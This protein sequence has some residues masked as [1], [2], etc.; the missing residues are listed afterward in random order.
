MDEVAGSHAQ[1]AC[2]ASGADTDEDRSS[3]DDGDLPSASWARSG[4]MRHPGIRMRTHTREREQ[5]GGSEAPPCRARRRAERQTWHELD[6]HRE[7]SKV[8]GYL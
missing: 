2:G 8:Q 3:A 7:R 4:A 1:I 6:L 5:G